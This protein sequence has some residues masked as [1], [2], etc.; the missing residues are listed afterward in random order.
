MTGLLPCAALGDSVGHRRVFA[1]GVAV[2]TVA[3]ALCALSPSLP[4]LVAARF[5]QGLG[6]TAVM[7]DLAAWEK[8]EVADS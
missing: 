3:S 1:I 4:W 6:G 8:A 2:F 7:F 5:L